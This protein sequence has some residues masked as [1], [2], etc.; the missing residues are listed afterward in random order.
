LTPLCRHL[1]LG[2]PRS[3]TSRRRIAACPVPMRPSIARLTHAFL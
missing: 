1:S 2:A 3:V